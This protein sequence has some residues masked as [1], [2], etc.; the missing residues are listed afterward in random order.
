MI[1]SPEVLSA[2][3]S[4]EVLTRMECDNVA[5]PST[6][7]NLKKLMV[8]LMCVPGFSGG[9]CEE[10]DHLFNLMV[11]DESILSGED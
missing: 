8:S 7:S 10:E 3:S 4:L 11:E 5:L 2:F 1:D 6:P 9:V